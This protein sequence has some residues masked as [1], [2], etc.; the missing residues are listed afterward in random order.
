M[1]SHQDRPKATNETQESA[2]RGSAGGGFSSSRP[3]SAHELNIPALLVWLLVF[4]VTAGV[5]V[6]IFSLLGV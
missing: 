5:W 3:P 6:A 4:T 1:H 2:T